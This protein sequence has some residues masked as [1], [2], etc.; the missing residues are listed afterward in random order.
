[1]CMGYGLHL[2]G[3]GA[4]VFAGELS[5][6]VDSGMGNIKHI[7]VVANIVNWKRRGVVVGGR[8]HGT[9]ERRDADDVAN[10]QRSRIP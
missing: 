3:K 1:M 7:F 8:N 2:S 5:A 10:R 4:V 6:A 9:V